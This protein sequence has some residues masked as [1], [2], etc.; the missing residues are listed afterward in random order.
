MKIVTL[1]ELRHVGFLG[2]EIF[3]LIKIFITK[4]VWT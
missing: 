2:I 4:Y 1:E 3:T